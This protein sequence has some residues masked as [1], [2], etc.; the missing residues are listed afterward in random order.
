MDW[1]NAVKA[2]AKT[3]SNVGS[4]IKINTSTTVKDTQR[5]LIP[6]DY[7]GYP[8]SY[9]LAKCEIR[10]VLASKLKSSALESAAKEKFKKPVSGVPAWVQP[11]PIDPKNPEYAFG[12]LIIL[13]DK[14]YGFSTSTPTASSKL[15]LQSI[16]LHELGH[17]LGV[18]GI[19]V[20][21]AVMHDE[22]LEIEKDPLKIEV[23]LE[24]LGV[25]YRGK[26]KRSLTQSDKDVLKLQVYPNPSTPGPASNKPTLTLNQ[27]SNCREGPSIAYVVVYSYPEGSKLEIIGKYGSG[28]WQ[29]PH[30]M[31]QLTRKKVCWI[32]DRGNTVSG[33]TS[34][35][36]TVQPPPL[37]VAPA[38]EN[39]GTLPIYD[40]YSQTVVDHM[41]C[42]EASA[43]DWEL[44]VWSETGE[45]VYFSSALFGDAAKGVY[46]R[47]AKNI[48]S[49]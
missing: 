7:S 30:N 29:V 28:W 41:S 35:V 16:A 10:V 9:K 26:Q 5:T 6:L 27:N 44:D 17:A 34:N 42:T 46:E 43:Y 48:C 14:N 45:P 37:P 22:I 32:Y 2:A 49:W 25:A 3:W 1:Q 11:Y 8:I 40:F 24:R 39:G 38:E 20:T 12:Y 31:P 36:S 23:D 47:D 33:N 19:R 15:D 4:R 13:N 21:G 18:G